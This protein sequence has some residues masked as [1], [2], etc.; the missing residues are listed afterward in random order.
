MGSTITWGGREGGGGEARGCWGGKG[1]RVWGQ[2]GR[3]GGGD[4]DNPRHAQNMTMP[5]CH[6][7]IQGAAPPGMPRT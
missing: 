4:K 6:D 2:G 1:E 7:T 5:T 3:G